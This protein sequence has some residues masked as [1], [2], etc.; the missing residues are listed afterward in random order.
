MVKKIE[1]YRELSLTETIDIIEKECKNQGYYIKIRNNTMII[2]KPK[3]VINMLPVNFQVSFVAELLSKDGGTLITGKFDVPRLF[4]Q[5]CVSVF[6]LFSCI[7]LLVASSE[8]RSILQLL[9]YLVCL[10]SAGFI[11][12]KT[13]IALSKIYFTN[14]NELVLKLLGSL[15]DSFPRQ[16]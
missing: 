8:N 3:L 2:R 13:Y 10:G 16:D 15:A 7:F 12:I 1:F 14:Q 6:L 9:P 4:Y 5:I 11:A